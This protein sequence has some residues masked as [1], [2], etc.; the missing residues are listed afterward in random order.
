MLYSIPKVL[1]KSCTC[2]KRL[3]TV[4][5]RMGQVNTTYGCGG[6]YS[7]KPY[8]P[9]RLAGQREERLQIHEEE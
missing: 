9:Q 5:K 1:P 2:S 6:E 8:H 4:E 7:R 3:R